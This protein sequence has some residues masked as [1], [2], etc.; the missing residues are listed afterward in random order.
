MLQCG[1]V[2]MR[3]KFLAAIFLLI[4]PFPAMAQNFILADGEYMDTTSVLPAGCKYYD[5]YYYQVGGKYP[6]SSETILKSAHAFLQQK[7][8]K[9]TGSGYI[10]FRFTVGCDG[11]VIA[12]TQVL[13]TD[14][15]Y[16]KHTFDKQFVSELYAFFKTL[17]KWKVARMPATNEAIAYAAFITFKIK[18]GEV[19]N[20]V[21]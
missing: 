13:Q 2:S 8:S 1:S 18:N 17:T 4:L 9:Y 19:I 5:V 3:D 10:T 6:E 16:T 11:K 14:E 12:K 7:N 20:I 21:P 15:R